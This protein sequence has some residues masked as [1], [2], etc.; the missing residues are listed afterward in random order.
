MRPYL[1]RRLQARDLPPCAPARQ[2]VERGVGVGA[3]E[4]GPT[5]EGAGAAQAGLGLKHGRLW[6]NQG[7][8]VCMIAR[9]R[10][11]T[12]RVKVYARHAERRSYLESAGLND[13]DREDGRNAAGGNSLPASIFRIC[14]ICD[15]I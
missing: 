2:E 8:E 7:V 14:W 1:V 13:C 15:W 9:E 4:V 10:T 11:D 6:A 3:Y 12:A 5:H